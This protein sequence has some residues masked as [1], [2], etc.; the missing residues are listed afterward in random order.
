M[1]GIDR[2]VRDINQCIRS[3][4]HSFLGVNAAPPVDVFSAS[5]QHLV[6]KF[7]KLAACVNRGRAIFT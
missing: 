1:S 3:Q 2:K 6:A 4:Q 5:A 7:L